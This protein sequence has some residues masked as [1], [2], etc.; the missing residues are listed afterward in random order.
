MAKTKSQ[1]LESKWLHILLPLANQEL[2][3]TAIMEEVLLRTG[4]AIRLWPG[5]P[6]GALRE[7][8]S[9]GLIQEVEPPEEAPTEGAGVVSAP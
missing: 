2:R 5:T 4:G 7:M 3:G 9:Q 8:A 1:K 6:Y